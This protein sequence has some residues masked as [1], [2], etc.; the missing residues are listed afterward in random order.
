MLLGEQ[1]ASTPV[2]KGLSTA[3]RKCRNTKR[4]HTSSSALAAE[5]P[6]TARLL[7]DSWTPCSKRGFLPQNL[8]QQKRS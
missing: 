2:P 5:V 7:I 6:I 8:Q 1:L 3:P 4:A